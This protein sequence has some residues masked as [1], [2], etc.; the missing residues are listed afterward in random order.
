MTNS[1]LTNLRYRVRTAFDQSRLR[2]TLVAAVEVSR[3]F[4]LLSILGTAADYARITQHLR[5]LRR[6]GRHSFLYRW[7]TKEPDPDVIVIDL[8]ETYTVGSILAGVDRLTDPLVRSYQHSKLRNIADSV[9]ISLTWIA[10][11]RV[12]RLLKRAL[13]PP[14]PPGNRSVED[15]RTQSDDDRENSR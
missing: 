14:D 10:A 15:Y 6:W 9:A 2:R 8:R 3:V 13:T 1:L 11:T 12:G 4:T 5:T 7:L